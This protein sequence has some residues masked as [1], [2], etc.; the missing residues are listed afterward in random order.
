MCAVGKY[1]TDPNVKKILTEAD[2]IGTPATRA[3]IIETL[4]ERGYVRR[5]KQTIVSTPTG[6]ALI[7][8]LPQIATT[9][10]MTAVWEAAMRAIQNGTQSLDSFLGRVGAQLEELVAQGRMLGRITVASAQPRPSAGNAARPDKFKPAR[11]PS[12]G[13]RR[14]AR[15][16]SQT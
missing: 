5:D 11:A 13:R 9:P 8:S 6:Q 14:R 16:W 10:D 7:A 3:A 2:G 15:A 1:V 12:G 4:F